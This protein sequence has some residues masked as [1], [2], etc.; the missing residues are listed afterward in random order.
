[1]NS[2][3]P[4]VEINGLCVDDVNLAETRPEFFLP[5]L[6]DVPQNP[7][8]ETLK[9]SLD[10]K[11]LDDV[12]VASVLDTGLQ[13]GKPSILQEKSPIPTPGSSA[14]PASA[15]R[16]P[17]DLWRSA[18]ESRQIIRHAIKSWDTLRSSFPSQAS[19]TPF[20]SEQ[21]SNVYMAARYHVMPQLRHPSI[22]R[23]YATARDIAMGLRQTILGMSSPLHMWD[24]IHEHFV[25][26]VV[27][28]G[29]NTDAEVVIE[30]NDEIISQS[31][32]SR[33]LTIGTIMRRLDHLVEKMRARPSSSKQAF[34]SASGEST[35]HAF[36]HALSAVL[37]YMGDELSSIAFP[38]NAFVDASSITS[39][40]LR[41]A[42]F[43]EIARGIGSL[44]GVD[45]DRNPKSYI[46]IPDSPAPLL[47]HVYTRL[48][49]LIAQRAPRRLLALVSHLLSATSQPYFKSLSGTLG[50]GTPVAS[51]SKAAGSSRAGAYPG[52]MD[53]GFEEYEEETEEDRLLTDSANLPA[54]INDELADA[55]PRAKKSLQLLY[56]ASPGHPLCTGDN[57]GP[58]LRWIWTEAE[59]R[60][61]WGLA[62]RP[63]EDDI[64]SN[65]CD[66]ESMIRPKPGD[67][68]APIDPISRIYKP[69][70]DFFE[71]FDH[72]PSA[73]ALGS[74]AQVHRSSQQENLRSFV[75]AYP[76]A[77]PSLSPTLTLLT[78]LVLAPLVKHISQLSAAV[79]AT[80]LPQSSPSIATS[81]PVSS[82]S[83]ILDLHAQ[84]VILRSYLLLTSP[85]FKWRLSGAL[86]SDSDSD[87][88][89]DAGSLAARFRI[90]RIRSAF[91]TGHSEHPSPPVW[92]IGLA[93]ALTGRETWPPGGADLSFVLRTVIVDS[94]QTMST[95]R[96]VNSK[97]SNEGPELEADEDA[98]PRLL[99][100]TERRLGFAI[101]DL[102]TGPGRDRWLNPL[103]IEALDFLYIDYKP[104]HPTEVVITSEALNKYQR[105]FSYL[106]RVMRVHHVTLALF[107]MSRTAYAALF[108]TFSAANKRFLQLR[109][110]MHSFVTALLTYTFDTAIGSNFDPFLSRLST[111][112]FADVFEL[113]QEHS[114]MM[115][116]ILSSCLLRSAQRA[117]A[118]LLMGCLELVLDLG[119]LASRVRGGNLE[120]YRAVPVLDDLHSKYRRR[121]TKLVEALRALTDANSIESSSQWSTQQLPSGENHVKRAPG[122]FNALKDLTSRLEGMKW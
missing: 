25:L 79:L 30:G 119:I 75:N 51:A 18:A 38:E 6:E 20:L 24:P 94:L 64:R 54:F 102:P 39:T 53:N 70:L 72:E 100:E 43:E 52:G 10:L 11:R 87:D 105:I 34:K 27:L 115:D 5:K 29:K 37:E 76:N 106:L 55:L 71:V 58:P 85:A 32:L 41:Y 3:N 110:S 81:P 8:M 84:L 13:W 57:C 78:E 65:L 36:T 2:L 21:S 93:P 26:E 90:K 80:F 82:L 114:K 28:Q 99:E 59:V 62:R 88:D 15:S 12:K 120:E 118:D 92:A 113:A 56:A 40:W 47:S 77:L 61:A 63:S 69:G 33:F 44:C 60:E 111:E 1:M 46:P 103:S 31:V 7:I 16:Y 42:E 89:L 83:P 96:A 14:K 19:S 117:A 35:M 74:L 97:K 98:A 91:S 23:V 73:F 67:E 101:R 107:R 116:E 121:V 112:S 50:Y 22:A 108:P 95:Q 86:F 109:F 4:L 66:Q 49:S 104:P 48:S 45:Y 122:G 68:S 17:G 9:L